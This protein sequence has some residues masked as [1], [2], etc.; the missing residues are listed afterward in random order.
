MVRK[1]R[2]NLIFDNVKEACEQ[3]VS[4]GEKVTVRNVLNITGG[5]FATVSEFIK[6]WQE[7]HAASK[8][9]SLPKHLMDALKSAYK[10]MLKEQETLY[11]EKLEREIARTHEA[12]KEIVELES[13]NEKLI[14]QLKS[15]TEDCQAKTK[16]YEKE[17]ALLNARFDDALQREQK[18]MDELETTRKKLHEA[19]IK[20]A[21]L[22]AEVKSNKKAG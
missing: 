10:D 18:L 5:N 19:E 12:L 7:Q 21:V 6:K 11:S 17:A 15:T 9:I 8:E 13:N 16:A 4:D 14:S 2:D 20:L 3:L 22:Q 1:K